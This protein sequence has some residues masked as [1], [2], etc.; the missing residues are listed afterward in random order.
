[1]PIL[2]LQRSSELIRFFLHLRHDA[3]RIFPIKADSRG[4]ACEL[5]TFQRG[6]QRSGDAVKQRGRFPFRMS[7]Y[8]M[9][10][11][12]TPFFRFDL[13]PISQY[14]RRIFCPGLPKNVR[15]AANHLVVNLANHVGNGEAAFFLCNL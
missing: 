6:R 4:L 5:K 12:R 3:V 8:S 1:M 9:F 15:V 7:A 11:V 13:L 2:G 14:F 10:L